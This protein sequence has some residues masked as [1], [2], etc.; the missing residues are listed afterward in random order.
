M[1]SIM[2]GRRW[3]VTK[4]LL[5]EWW[6]LR[7][8]FRIFSKP[9]H[10][11]HRRSIFLLYDELVKYYLPFREKSIEP[12]DHFPLIKDHI[13][14][15]IIIGILSKVLLRCDAFLDLGYLQFCATVIVLLTRK[16]ARK[17]PLLTSR[18]NKSWT[19]N[20]VSVVYLFSLLEPLSADTQC[21]LNLS[22]LQNVM[23]RK[24]SMTI[25]TWPLPNSF[26]IS[27]YPWL[28]NS[29]QENE[30]LKTYILLTVV[31]SHNNHDHD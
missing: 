20:T 23:N 5:H 21:K 22:T 15:I 2:L 27:S 17:F 18:I 16:L 3:Y 25:T 6:G 29:P 14:I 31:L 11:I 7:I 1:P 13:G 9:S 19:L 8:P 26:N 28:C 4:Y 10:H 24:C 30:V 12:D